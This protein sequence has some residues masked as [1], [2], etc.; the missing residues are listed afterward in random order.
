MGTRCDFYVGKGPEAEWL[1]SVGY[2]GVPTDYPA[3]IDA[4]TEEAYRAAVAGELA[5][6]D[7]ATTPD[8]GWPWPWAT[9]ASSDFA[10]AF[11]AGKAWASAGGHAFYDPHAPPESRCIGHQAF[12]NMTDRQRVTIDARSGVMLFGRRRT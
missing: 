7:D 11:F 8:M 3:I 5:G 2:D 4:T 6:R 1:G 9:S 10:V 12:P